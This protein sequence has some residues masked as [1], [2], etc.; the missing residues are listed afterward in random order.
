MINV[1]LKLFIMSMYKCL[2]F[3]HFRST[4]KRKVG[5]VS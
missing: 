5:A 1:Q 4:K 3:E 2:S